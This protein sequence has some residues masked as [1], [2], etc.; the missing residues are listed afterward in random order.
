MTG[1]VALVLIL[2]AH[3]SMN[4][5]ADSE[6]MRRYSNRSPLRRGDPYRW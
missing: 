3:V 2:I 5:L 6:H 4:V 1:L